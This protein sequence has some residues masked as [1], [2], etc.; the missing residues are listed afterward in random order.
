M[1]Y[2]VSTHLTLALSPSLSHTPAAYRLQPR[3]FATCSALKL[4][5][6]EKALVPTRWGP[7][8]CLRSETPIRVNV[9][10]YT[11]PCPAPDP[12]RANSNTYS[13]SLSLSLSLLSLSLPQVCGV[14]RII[15]S[16]LAPSTETVALE[17]ERDLTNSSCERIALGSATVLTHFVR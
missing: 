15:R 9:Y 2:L 4:M 8:P 13:L 16:T 10:V 1:V 7:P 14:A 5:K 3:R 17:H 12:C 11:P 6:Y